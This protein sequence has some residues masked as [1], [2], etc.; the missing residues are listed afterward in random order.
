VLDTYIGVAY[1]I[2]FQ[3][4]NNVS[5]TFRK[6]PDEKSSVTAVSVCDNFI[7]YGISSGYHDTIVAVSYPDLSHYRHL[8]ECP[9]ELKR[10]LDSVWADLACFPA[11]NPIDSTIWLAF[12]FY[13]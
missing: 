7:L 10:K 5:A 6:R 4:S 2:D 11:F 12:M 8:F 3:D 9:P 1:K 13:N